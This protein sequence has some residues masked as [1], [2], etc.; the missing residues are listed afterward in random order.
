MAHLRLPN[1]RR[2][3]DTRF[4]RS[5]AKSTR[6]K[7][8][9]RS[10]RRSLIG[11]RSVGQRTPAQRRMPRLR[12]TRGTSSA[13]HIRAKAAPRSAASRRLRQPA[14]RARRRRPAAGRRRPRLRRTTS[15]PPR[16]SSQ[17]RSP[18][19][20]LLSY[21][22]AIT[23][24]RMSR[25][26]FLWAIPI[27]PFCSP[28]LGNYRLT[29]YGLGTNRSFSRS[30]ASRRRSAGASPKRPKGEAKAIDATNFSARVGP[31]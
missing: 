21:G 30:S 17:R 9:S 23:R 10:F 27:V 12:T 28:P 3:S 19:S 22:K 24:P 1:H 11:T 13:F 18:A 6:R 31:P 5:L 8:T 7:C 4:R 14:A 16:R 15:S 29:T 20:R 2:C 26:G 25:R